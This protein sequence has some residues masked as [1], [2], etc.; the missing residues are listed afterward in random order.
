MTGLRGKIEDHIGSLAEWAKINLTQIAV[1]QSDS[2]PASAA[3]PQLIRQVVFICTAAEQETIQCCDSSA[4]ARQGYRQ[5]AAKESCASEQ[6]AIAEALSDVD[7]LL[8]T[9]ERVI[10]KKR[11][12]RQ[13]ALQ[14]LLTGQTRLP[15]FEDQWETKPLRQDVTLISGQHVLAQHC[16]TVGK[17]LPY[18]T[19]RQTFP[20]R[21]FS[22]RNSQTMQPQPAARAI[23]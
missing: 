19:G 10:A 17:G 23:S 5:I 18:L 11:D 21:A 1:D 22:R 2:R 20:M 4:R 7:A 3:C 8:A 14:Q 16:N 15:G 12:I 9:L 6:R 13:A